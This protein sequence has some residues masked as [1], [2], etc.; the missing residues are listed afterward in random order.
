MDD[1]LKPQL[2]P[3]AF[4]G[5][6]RLT[7]QTLPGPGGRSLSVSSLCSTKLARCRRR[8]LSSAATMSRRRRRAARRHRSFVAPALAANKATAE[9]RD[10][11][12]SVLR[13][14]GRAIRSWPRRAMTTDSPCSR[15]SAANKTTQAPSRNCAS[16]HYND[17]LRK[18]SLELSDECRGTACGEGD[19]AG[20]V[21]RIGPS[22]NRQNCWEEICSKCVTL[23]TGC[24]PSIR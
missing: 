14:T 1:V 15:R 22:R 4:E 23:R 21:T 5:G 17:R 20:G 24:R 18:G 11:P 2:L 19:R 8:L 12:V 6:S 16:S 9:L 3:D 13:K 10:H 7:S